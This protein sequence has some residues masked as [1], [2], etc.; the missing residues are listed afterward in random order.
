MLQMMWLTLLHNKLYVW[1]FKLGW[2]DSPLILSTPLLL[3]ISISLFLIGAFFGAL[4]VNGIGIIDITAQFN[5]RRMNSNRNFDDPEEDHTTQSDPEDIAPRNIN[6]ENVTHSENVINPENVTHPE[7]VA[8]NNID[9]EK[10]AKTVKLKQE[11][12]SRFALAIQGSGVGIWD[13]DI[14]TNEVCYDARFQQILGF[15]ALDLSALEF[16]YEKVVCDL[17]SW[18]TRL[19]PNDRESTLLAIKNHLEHQIPCQVECRLKTK[20]EDYIW[21]ECR[22]Q[23]LWNERGQ[24]I[25]I[26]GSIIDIAKHK[27][28]EE[29]LRQLTEELEQRVESR[30]MELL[31]ANELLLE[32]VWDRRQAQEALQASESQLRHQAQ[33]LEQT[34]N[35]LRHAQTQMVQAE[36]MS[37][38]GQLVAGVAHEINN[39]VNF[40]HGNLIHAHEYAQDLLK[41]VQLYQTYYSEPPTEI[42]ETIEDIDLDFLMADLLRLINSMQVGSERICE[43]VK[44]LKNF[45]RLDEAEFKTVDLH[46]GIDSTLMILHNRLKDKPDSPGIQ[47]VKAY[48][49]LPAVQCYPGQLNQVFMNVLNNAIDAL[50]DY[51]RHRNLDEIKAHPSRIKIWTTLVVNPDQKPDHHDYERADFAE[52]APQNWVEIHIAD[53]GPGIPESTQSKLFD[54]FFTTKPVGKGTGLGLSISYQI[55]VERHGGILTCHSAPGQGAEFVIQIPVQQTV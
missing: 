20:T 47:V 46:E 35:E 6:S 1:P 36:K 33:Q 43:I 40:I 7:N 12:Q 44:S 49:E 41:L 5:A 4:I 17:Q 39:P 30:T 3:S 15:Q 10:D 2:L 21:V 48:G 16:T 54:P 37:S 22:A 50:V 38:L 32:E 29:Q 13:W 27:Q 55:V 42:K 24:P 25:R 19:H 52:H 9:P 51:D 14:V 53:N 26:A 23:A 31:T 34:L 28:V 18:T 45:S 8:L 11:I